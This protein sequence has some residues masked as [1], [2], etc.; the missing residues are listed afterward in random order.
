MKSV[1]SG[2][3]FAIA[4]ALAAAPAQ[5]TNGMRMIGFGAS[6]VGMGG[7]SVALPLDAASVIT[8]PAGMNELG[9]RIDFGASYFSP[10]VSYQAQE[11][12]QVPHPGM[13]VGSVAKFDSQRGASPVPAF[14]LVLPL[15]E[16]VWFG[17]GA[18]GVAGMGVDYAQ[19]LYG[20]VTYSSYSQMRFAPGLSWKLNEQVS[21]GL[22]ANVMWAQMGFDAASGFGQ[23]PHQVASAFGIGGTVGAHYSPVEWFTVGAAYESKSFFQN[24]TFQIPQHTAAD[25]QTGQPVTIPGGTDSSTFRQPSS[26][27]AGLATNP[28]KPLMIAFDVAYIRWS[29]TNGENMPTFNPS[30]SAM[31]WNLDWSDQVV[32]KVGAQYEVTKKVALRVGYNYGKMPLNSARAFENIAFPAIA[33]HHFTGGVGLSL[34][35]KF[36]LNLA[37]MYVPEATL[38]GANAQQQYIASYTTKMSQVAFDGGVAY[39]F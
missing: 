38:N 1:A 5:A 26:F 21:L 23:V 32:F 18:Y 9:A 17:L 27:T 12:G 29:E 28:Y 30:S 19:N 7:A 13:A 6:Q 3:L 36:T 33:E 35:D 22:T 37:V 16:S 39:R 34:T 31:R 14:G 2:L 24:F 20:G 8:N 11:V 25:P 4:L 10:T 15:G